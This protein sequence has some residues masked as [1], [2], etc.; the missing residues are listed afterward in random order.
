MIGFAISHYPSSAKTFRTTPI[1]S[2]IPGPMTYCCKFAKVDVANG[3]FN[4]GAMPLQGQSPP[5]PDS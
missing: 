1:L 2:P 4:I 5:P 3:R